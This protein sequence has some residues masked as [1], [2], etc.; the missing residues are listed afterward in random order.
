[1][2]RKTHQVC[3]GL[4]GNISPLERGYGWEQARPDRHPRRRPGLN[5]ARGPDR[6]TDQEQ[7]AAVG[8]T[9]QR[10]GSVAQMDRGSQSGG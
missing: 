7:Q 10:G 2:T 8:P 4:D 6:Q 5:R 1:M 9:A 3:T